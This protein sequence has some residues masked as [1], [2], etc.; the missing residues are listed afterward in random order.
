MDGL[1]SDDAS[2]TKLG[3]TARVGDGSKK[4]W[5]E[6][7]HAFPE[8]STTF[9]SAVEQ[10][11]GAALEWRSKVRLQDGRNVSYDGVTMLDFDQDRIVNLRTYFDT[12]PLAFPASVAT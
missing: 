2:L 11:S 9:V 6:Y 1:F 4:F 8:A 10:E 5:A 7:L 3:R 12:E